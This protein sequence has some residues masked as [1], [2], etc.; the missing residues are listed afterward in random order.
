MKFWVLGFLE[1]QFW[2]LGLQILLL[3]AVLPEGMLMI[4]DLMGCNR[5]VIQPS[6][7][8]ADQQFFQI[9]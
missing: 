8:D 2:A 6:F 9:I 7:P 5:D 4:C 3:V 1:K